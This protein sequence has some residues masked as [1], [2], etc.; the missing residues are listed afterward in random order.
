[1]IADLKHEILSMVDVF[2]WLTDENKTQIIE[3]TKETSDENDLRAIMNELI[4][5][6][7][8]VL[9]LLISFSKNKKDVSPYDIRKI[10]IETIHIEMDNNR[11]ETRLIREIEEK[12]DEKEEWSADDILSQLEDL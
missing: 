2:Y 11:T 1:M 6:K 7:N 5:Q 9:E 12:R 8:F 10:V 3:N 4:E